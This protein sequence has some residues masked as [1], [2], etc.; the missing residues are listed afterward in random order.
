MC[1]ILM[2]HSRILV[3]QKI[4][5]TQCTGLAKAKMTK[6]FYVYPAVEIQKINTL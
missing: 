2:M 4:C 1:S 3:I 6:I 5:L